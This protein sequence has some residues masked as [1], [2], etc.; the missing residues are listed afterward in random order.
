MPELHKFL[1]LHV[2]YYKISDT[3]SAGHVVDQTCI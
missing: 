1:R 2:S 3:T